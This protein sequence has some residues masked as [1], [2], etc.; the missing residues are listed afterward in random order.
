MTGLRELYKNSTLRVLLLSI[1]L[2][3]FFAG[4]GAVSTSGRYE[5]SGKSEDVK[6]EKTDKI[7]PDE[8]ESFNLTPY[9]PEIILDETEFITDPYSETSDAWYEY[10]ER[11][12]SH[13][14]KKIVGTI[15]G[16]RVQV[17][18][19]DELDEANRINSELSSLIPNQRCYVNFEPPFYKVK[20]GD[21]K[22]NSEAN[23]M[24]FRLNQLGF[25]EAK[26]VR[27]TINK[28]E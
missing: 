1:I 4:C 16:F 8:K 6:E 10:E 3:Y 13:E 15:D 5:T 11:S 24:R 2:S 12:E 9:R 23:D 7:A 17:I 21:F 20:L 18:A 28:F 14:N 19:T 26:V 25:T 22:E 27:E